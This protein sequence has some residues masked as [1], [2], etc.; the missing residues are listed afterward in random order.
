MLI[1]PHQRTL[2]NDLRGKVVLMQEMAGVGNPMV[3]APLFLRFDEIL[4]EEL[5]G[6]LDIIPFRLVIDVSVRMQEYARKVLEDITSEAGGI[7]I[8]HRGCP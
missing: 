3:L 5:L 8:R 7:F 1:I 2:A 4:Q 6:E